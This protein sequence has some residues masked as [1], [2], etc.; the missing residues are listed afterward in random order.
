MGQ[1]TGNNSECLD[2]R[3]ETPRSSRR[4]AST[5]ASAQT[6]TLMALAGIGSERQL[7]TVRARHRRN[8]VRA[9]HGFSAWSR[10]AC[11][12]R[13]VA[14]FNPAA[15]T[16]A[17]FPSLFSGGSA[18]RLVVEHPRPVRALA[19][20]DIEERSRYQQERRG[21][22]HEAWSTASD[23]VSRRDPGQFSLALDSARTRWPR[24][25]RSGF[26]IAG[27]PLAR[28]LL[29]EGAASKSGMTR[30]GVV[31]RSPSGQWQ[32]SSGERNRRAIRGVHAGWVGLAFPRRDSG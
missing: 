9:R 2:R 17:S 8:T 6:G 22:A 23:T 7:V 13:G 15:G 1:R 26:R 12:A 11:A 28:S 25:P 16:S 24:A 31:I 14:N 21:L 3:G 18:A 20:L 27:L 32:E 30:I 10:H 29:G 4:P 19:G 5:A